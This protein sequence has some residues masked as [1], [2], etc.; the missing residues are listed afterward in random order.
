MSIIACGG[1]DG[2]TDKV[3][4]KSAVEFYQDLYPIHVKLVAVVDEFNSLL[5]KASSQYISDSE[6]LNVCQRSI[7]SL[8]SIARDLSNAYAPTS[9][10]QLKDDTASAINLGI[11]A[12]NLLHT[13]VIKEDEKFRHD[14]DSKLL[15]CNKYL[16]HAA[17]EWDDGL[18]NYDIKS[19]E[20]LQ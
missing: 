13:Y 18:A 20:I 8:E 14:A 11:E 10:R 12:F 16:M 9:L 4:R 3:E 7:S 19:S 15:E 1:G 6:I 2:G 5:N 17:D